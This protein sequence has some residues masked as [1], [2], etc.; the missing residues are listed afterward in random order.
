[1][2]PHGK[3]QNGSTSVGS[4]NVEAE[5][6]GGILYAATNDVL[7]TTTVILESV[8]RNAYECCATKSSV[9]DVIDH[10]ATYVVFGGIPYE[11]H[12]PVFCGHTIKRVKLQ[13]LYKM[14]WFRVAAINPSINNIVS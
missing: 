6:I 10:R 14:P 5:T 13:Y 12:C 7:E 11:L 9:P 1:M 2:W 4:Q 8:M 3:R